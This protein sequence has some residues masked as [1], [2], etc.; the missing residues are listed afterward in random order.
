MSDSDVIQNRIW[1]LVSCDCNGGNRTASSGL[2]QDLQAIKA[3]PSLP[4]PSGSSLS[5]FG[6]TDFPPQAH[7][8]ARPY[9]TQKNSLREQPN[10]HQEESNKEHS[11][12]STSPAQV[13]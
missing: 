8:F 4:R 12:P 1:L 11:N 7:D 5:L 6:L 10:R 13:C 9:R 3:A 2:F